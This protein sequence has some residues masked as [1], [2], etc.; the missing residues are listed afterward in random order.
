MV[1]GG[2]L[3]DN[4]DRKI[5]DKTSYLFW[6]DHWLNGIRLKVRFSMLFNLAENKMASFTEMNE[7]GWW[8]NGE[9]WK[10]RGRFHVWENEL[11]GECIER[12][13]SFVLQVDVEDHWAWNLHPSSYYI[14]NMLRFFFLKLAITIIRL[15]SKF[16]G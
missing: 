11:V 2:W 12:L 14:V 9:A 7:L 1:G 13:T 5:G 15:I 6:K 16:C 4:I 3:I 8:E 10:W